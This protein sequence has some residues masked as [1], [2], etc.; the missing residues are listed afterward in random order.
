MSALG[1]KPS[2]N[3]ILHYVIMIGLIFLLIQALEIAGMHISLIT[4]TPIAILIG[5]L[6]PKIVRELGIAP[7][8]WE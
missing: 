1:K 4:G 5:I 3:P 2:E 7:T 6:Y 8:G